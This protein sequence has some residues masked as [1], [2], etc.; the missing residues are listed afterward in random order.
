MRR[1]RGVLNSISRRW[2]QTSLTVGE[3]VVFPGG[4]FV[5]IIIIIIIGG[6]GAQSTSVAR[7]SDVRS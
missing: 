6:G 1:L 5:L 7:L 4:D 3:A 2:D